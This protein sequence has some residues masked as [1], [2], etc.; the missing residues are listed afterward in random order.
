VDPILVIGSVTKLRP[1]HRD[2]VVVSGSHGGVYPAYCAVGAG[3]RAVILNDAGVGVDRAGVAALAYCQAL[4]I[5]AATVSHRSARIGDAKDMMRRGRISFVNAAAGLL[6]CRVGADCAACAD[7]LSSAPTVVLAP[8]VYV[9]ARF[10]LRE[11]PGE[12]PVIAVD[13]ASLVQP[14]D[15]GAI[16]VTGSHGGLVGGR[17]EAA[18]P[19]DALAA[20]FNDAGIGVDEAGVGRLPALDQRGIAAATVSADSARIGDARSTYADG[21]LS[22]VNESAARC[23]VAIGMSAREFVDKVIQAKRPLKLDMA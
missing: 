14:E 18:L 15:A 22:R 1:E 19:V 2:R 11:D 13:S 5:P 17:P 21:F 8:P 9:E 4:G 20:L 3:A 10:T 16:I 7:L 12:P 23:G 6:G